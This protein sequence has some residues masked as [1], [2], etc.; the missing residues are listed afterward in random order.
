MPT[1]SRITQQV[2]RADRYSIY[3]DG[4]YSFSLS[5][6]QLA[7]SE[8]ASGKSLSDEQ[9]EEYK[10]TSEFG[11]ALQAAYRLLSYRQRSEHELAERLTRKGYDEPTTRLVAARLRQYKLLGDEEFAKVW[12]AQPK[13]ALRSRRRLQQELNQKRI[14]KELITQN[15]DEIG[16]EHDEMAIKQLIQKRLNKNTPIDRQK[17]VGYLSRQ[18]FQAHLIFKVIEQEFSE[19]LPR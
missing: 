19:L 1:V 3:I 12:V 13:S 6:D 8:L 10:K 17:L 16:A 18:G 9:V 7:E 2:K 14:D 5:T 15:L 4:A 11:K